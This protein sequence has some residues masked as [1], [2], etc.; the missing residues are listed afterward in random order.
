MSEL[1]QLAQKLIQAQRILLFP[2]VNMDGDTFGSCVALCLALRNQGKECQILAEEEPPAYLS[3]LD[4]DYTVTGP[5]SMTEPD[6]CIALDCSDAGRLAGRRDAFVAGKETWSLDHHVTNQYFAQNN[7]VKTEAA[8]TAEIVYE[9]IRL[10]PI[11]LSKEIAEAI[12]TAI[13]TDTGSFQY[14]NTTSKTHLIAAELFEVGID[15]NQI[16]IQ[17]YQNARYEKFL[18][19]SLIY[20]TMERICDG[21][22]AL[23]SVTQEMLRQTGASME[24]TE[25][26]IESLRSIQGVEV[27]IFLKEY[28]KKMIKVSLRSKSYADVAVISAAYG[29]GGH[30]RAAGFSIDKPLQEVKE[31]I[32]LEACRQVKALGQEG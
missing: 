12:Y 11:Q 23:A 21:K 18:I 17:V 31:L 32:L 3:F 28:E 29:G 9:L 15:H 5:G 6:L 8:A 2:H 7:I 24:E 19:A 16:S 1:N 4:G 13:A 22:V 25:G 14:S 26:I 30:V 27:A 20:G 10:L